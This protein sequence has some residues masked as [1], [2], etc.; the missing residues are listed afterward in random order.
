MNGII[1]N[2]NEKESS[3]SPSSRISHELTSY[4][5]LKK[6]QINQHRLEPLNAA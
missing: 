3:Q 1:E 5:K 2:Q 4:L 6:R